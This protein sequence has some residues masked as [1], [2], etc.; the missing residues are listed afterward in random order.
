MGPTVPQTNPQLA[1]AT[2]PRAPYR[3]SY[4]FRDAVSSFRP[5]DT[6]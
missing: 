2:L 5:E 6:A 4:K 3:K 1:I